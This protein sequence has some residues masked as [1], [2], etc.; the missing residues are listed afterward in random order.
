MGDLGYQGG[1][2]VVFVGD[3]AA[4]RYSGSVFSPVADLFRH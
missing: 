1:Q 4:K 2:V 3:G